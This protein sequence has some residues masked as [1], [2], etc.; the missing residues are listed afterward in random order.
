MFGPLE[1]I[2]GKVWGYVLSGLALVGAVFAIFF[3]GRE[4]GK[5]SEQNE[6]L[7]ADM[8]ARD[9]AE[10]TS[11]DAMRATSRSHDS[12][13]KSR[14]QAE[15]EASDA[16]RRAKPGNT[17]KGGKW[18]VPLLL[19]GSLYACCS[20]QTVVQYPNIPELPLLARPVLQEWEIEVTEENKETVQS[21]VTNEARLKGAVKA[22]EEIIMGYKEFREN[23]VKQSDNLED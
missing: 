1:S 19:T 12:A 10:D 11:K 21:I 22:Y 6:Q 5:E 23:Y 7:R 15:R 2:V 13:N 20:P 3:Y 18:L 8:E 17:V 16:R 14:E 4:T 9:K